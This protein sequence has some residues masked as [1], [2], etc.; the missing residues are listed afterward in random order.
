MAEQL[1]AV[2]YAKK[3]N[4]MY[5]EYYCRDEGRCKYWKDCT[6]NGENLCN[7]N[8]FYSDRVKVGEN[9]GKDLAIP[10]I[11]FAGLEGVHADSLGARIPEIDLASEHSKPSLNV[12]YP[13]YRGVRYVLAYLLSKY[14]NETEPADAFAETLNDSNYTRFLTM[15]CL[16]NLYKCAFGK[17]KSGLDHTVGMKKHCLE[18]FMKEIDILK[19]DILVIQVVTN[20]PPKLWKGMLEKYCGCNV[21]VKTAVRDGRENTNTSVYKL[22]HQD[23][24]TPF[25]CVWTYHGNGG[26]YPQKKGG[27]FVN[28]EKYIKTELNPVLDATIDALRK[29]SEL[30]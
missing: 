24:G 14:F 20:R 12:N 19:P 10:K 4:E 15:F 22:Y 1:N 2:D 13:H 3:L 27:I 5:K 16:T 9:Y 18:I 6:G 7:Q 21:P 17:G 8:K 25:Y 26:P 23:D 29:D 11:V 28:N 30:S